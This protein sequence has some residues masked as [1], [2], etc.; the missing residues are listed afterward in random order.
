MQMSPGATPSCSSVISSAFSALEH[1][2][3]W[4]HWHWVISPACD[5]SLYQTWI[6]E[7]PEPGLLVRPHLVLYVLWRHNT[8]AKEF[9]PKSQYSS[10]REIRSIIWKKT[11]NICLFNKKGPRIW[12]FWG[13]WIG[14][15]KD[16]IQ[17]TCTILWFIFAFVV[18]FFPPTAFASYSIHLLFPYHQIKF[19]SYLM[20]HNL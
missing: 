9:P 8:K 16:G 1:W 20:S 15:K 6:T 3:S 18:C 10:H 4:G 19:F 11:S 5:K 2:R 13:V 7:F 17:S 12:F 14:L